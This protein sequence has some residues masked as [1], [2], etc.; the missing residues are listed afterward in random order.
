MLLQVD[1][2]TRIG[3]NGMRCVVL[4]RHGT[5]L[6]QWPHAPESQWNTLIDTAVFLYFRTNTPTHVPSPQHGTSATPTVNTGCCEESAC[7]PR[8]WLAP[9]LMG[10]PPS[11]RSPRT[12]VDFIGQNLSVTS[13]GRK[14]PF[15]GRNSG[16]SFFHMQEQIVTNLQSKVVCDSFCAAA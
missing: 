14:K 4:A 5:G 12:T 6:R 13:S 15:L 8:H 3:S 1:S 11:T 7:S 16:H 2:S 10:K 9:D